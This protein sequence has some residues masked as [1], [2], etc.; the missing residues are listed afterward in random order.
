MPPSASP[1]C[2]RRFFAEGAFNAAFVPLFAKEIEANGVDGA[3]KFSEE[4]FGI[5]FT[6]L[7]ILTIVDAAGDAAAGAHVIAPGFVDDTTKFD[8]T[9][10]MSIIMFPY[11]MC[12]SLTAMMSGILNSLQHYFIAAITP[13]LLNVVLTGVLLYALLERPRG[14]QDRLRSV[15]GRAGGGPRAT[16]CG[17]GRGAPLPAY[18]SASAVRA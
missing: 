14:H 12:M 5:L 4:V 1:T 16:A 11:L 18:R 15:L 2:F 6:V 17:A 3:R 7:L 9:V 10:R 13:V 8:I